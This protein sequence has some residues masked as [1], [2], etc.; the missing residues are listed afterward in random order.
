VVA[1]HGGRSWKGGIYYDDQL[2]K[3][4]PPGICEL[5]KRIKLFLW[6]GAGTVGMN[7]DLR[8]FCCLKQVPGTLDDCLCYLLVCKCLALTYPTKEVMNE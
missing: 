6:F 7:G 5:I 2:H 8:F 1:Q 3:F 4:I